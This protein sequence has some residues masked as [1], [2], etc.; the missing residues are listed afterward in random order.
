MG[1]VGELELLIK[2]IDAQLKAYLDN[3]RSPE[4][5]YKLSKELDKL[6][7]KHCDISK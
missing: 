3:R 1:E 4:E 5:V 7:I 2:K 6:I